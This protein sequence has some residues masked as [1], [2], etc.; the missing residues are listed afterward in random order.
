M[1]RKLSLW[2]FIISFSSRV[3]FFP[4][5]F[6]W[7]RTSQRPSI[8]RDRM[9]AIGK[10]LSPL[11]KLSEYSPGRYKNS[12]QHSRSD[13]I[14]SCTFEWSTS[15]PTTTMNSSLDQKWTSF[16]AWMDQERYFPSS[17]RIIRLCV[18]R[19]QLCVQYSLL[20]MEISNY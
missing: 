16:W 5:N 20:W 12:K 7:I 10:F 17:N 1:V 14:A 15:W 18:Y 9:N 19:V 6:C 11:H 13:G 8:D 2:I 3:A 4:I